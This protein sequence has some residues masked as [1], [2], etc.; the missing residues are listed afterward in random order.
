[1]GRAA[2]RQQERSDKRQRTAQHLAPPST[3][4]FSVSSSGADE[5]RAG[6]AIW[7]PWTW[8]W[9]SDIISELRK[10]TWPAR[11]ETTNLTFVVIVVSILV[12][13]V[14]GGADIGFSWLVEKILFR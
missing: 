5:R 12:A 11:Q 4:R 9:T 10:V 7:K 13:V 1:M 6:A 2:R 3:P 8:R 14:L